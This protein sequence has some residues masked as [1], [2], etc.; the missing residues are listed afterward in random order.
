MPILDP[1]EQ[2]SRWGES[3]VMKGAFLTQPGR[4]NL[5]SRIITLKPGEG[6]E[7]KYNMKKGAGLVFSWVAT[8]KVL[9]D[10]HGMPDVKPEGKFSADYFE[11]YDRDDKVGKTQF[12]GTFV[13][14]STGIHGWFWENPGTE[15]MTIRLITAGFY[16]WVFQNVNDKE[17]AFKP[18]DAYSL[19]SHPAVPDELVQ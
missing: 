13:A 10:F 14:P 17:S 7:I 18:M 6:M 9:Y 12:N 1:V 11:S 8:G 15:M 4:Y 3:A 5:D 16:D 2:P 19:P